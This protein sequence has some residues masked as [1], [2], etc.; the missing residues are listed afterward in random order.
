MPA[1]AWLT[2]R[3]EQPHPGLAIRLLQP[4]SWIYGGLAAIDR[5]LYAHG[6]RQVVQPPRPTIVVGNLVAGGA[7]KTPAVLA[8]IE[9]LRANGLRPGVVSRGYGR[10]GSGVTLV[11]ANA[12]A[13]EVGD[14]PVLIRQR[15]GAPVAVGADR[16]A[17]ARALCEAHTEVDVIV[18]D[19]GLQHHRLGRQ[20]EVVV[21][22]DRGLGNGRLLPAGP[23]RAHLQASAGAHRVVLYT[24][25]RPSTPLDGYVGER[26]LAGVTALDDWWSGRKDRLEPLA[27]LRGRPLL[28]M[29]GLARPEGFFAMLEAE[30]LR[31]ERLPLPDHA[32]LDPLPWPAGTPETVVTEKDAVKLRPR[33]TAGTRVWVARLDFVPEPAFGAALLS[34][35]NASPT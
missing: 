13:D 9:L 10:R 6:L 24:A 7:G 22:D 30:G 1:S 3:W 26:R 17:A 33:R 18:S 11:G 16:P 29:A 14:E 4:L 28:A 32:R 20:V 31:F 12:D 27:A 21:F 2:A 5:G 25:G 34:L 23:L 19:D 35:L 8:I 15:S